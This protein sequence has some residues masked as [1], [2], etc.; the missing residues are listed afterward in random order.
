MPK[1]A[2]C[3]E[4]IS[5]VTLTRLLKGLIISAFLVA[6]GLTAQGV[7]QG[8][9]Q[10]VKAQATIEKAFPNSSKCKRCHE[11]VFEEWETSPLSRSIH[12]PTFRAALDAYLTSS[13]EKDKGLC[14][15]CHAPHVREFSNHAHS[16]LLLST[17]SGGT[18]TMEL[19]T[20]LDPMANYLKSRVIL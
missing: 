16:V 15:R 8:M 4:D 10:D 9:A 3:A 12:T 19:L 20:T 5:T 14:F 6:L 11:R 18:S 7:Q 13:G 1:D 2:R 17:E